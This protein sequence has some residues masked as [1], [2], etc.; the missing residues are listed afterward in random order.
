VRFAR[1]LSS[2]W[3]RCRD[4]ARLMDMGAV[5]I[6]PTFSNAF[7]LSDRRDELT[8][9]ARK[10]LAAWRGPGPLL[11]VTHGSNIL[12]LTGRSP[13]SGEAVVVTVGGDGALTVAGSL[14]PPPR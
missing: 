7:V 1:V 6:E 3:C 14:E 11:V 10:V 9:G 2:P 8:A 4:T 12:A 13:A 5:E